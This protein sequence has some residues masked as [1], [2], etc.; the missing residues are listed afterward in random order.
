MDEPTIHRGLQAVE[1]L[2][3]ALDSYNAALLLVSTTPRLL[4]TLARSLSSGASE[5]VRAGWAA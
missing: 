1:Q 3:S 2:E 4:E 5:V